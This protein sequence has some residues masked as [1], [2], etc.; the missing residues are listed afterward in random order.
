MV[1]YAMVGSF[2]IMLN[3]GLIIA[4][5]VL[6]IYLILGPV[7]LLGFY[8]LFD[9]MAEKDD[10]DQ[11]KRTSAQDKDPALWSSRDVRQYLKKT[12]RFHSD[13]RTDGRRDERF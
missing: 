12:R 10:M 13:G 2:Q 7:V 3:V 4:A 9:R 6:A 1:G 11:R 8:A 5:A